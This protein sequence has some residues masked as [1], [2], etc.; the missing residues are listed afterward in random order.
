MRERLLAVALTP[1]WC[2]TAALTV[3]TGTLLYP[4]W[5]HVTGRDA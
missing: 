2:R 5:W 1:W 4:G 3:W